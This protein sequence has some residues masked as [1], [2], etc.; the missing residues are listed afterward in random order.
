MI[1]ITIKFGIARYW[2]EQCEQEI[3]FW[4]SVAADPD[5]QNENAAEMLADWENTKQAIAEANKSAR[6]ADE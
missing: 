4:K 1:T 5:R 6:R 3:E 2:L